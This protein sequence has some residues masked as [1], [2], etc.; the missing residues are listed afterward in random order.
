[1]LA[2]LAAPDFLFGLPDL[3]T[4]ASLG[5]G[6][7]PIGPVFGLNC[8]RRFGCPAG[9]ALLPVSFA[10]V[11]LAVLAAAQLERAELLVMP[12]TI[13]SLLSSPSPSPSMR[14]EGVQVPAVGARLMLLGAGGD[15]FRFFGGR[16]RRLGS[17]ADV[18]LSES[19]SRRMASGF[20]FGC[21][22]FSNAFIWTGAGVSAGVISISGAL[23]GAAGAVGTVGA[24]AGFGGGCDSVASAP[25]RDIGSGG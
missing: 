14:G 11:L 23:A 10:G 17:V 13:V 25:G 22:S 3:V 9:G 6:G 19:S 21:C 24:T 8:N 18:F 2:A 16:P 15:D 20:R 5:F 12:S 1:V 7:E 4:G